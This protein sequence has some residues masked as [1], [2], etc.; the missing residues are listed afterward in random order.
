MSVDYGSIYEAILADNRQLRAQVAE[1]QAAKAG[2]WQ[3]APDGAYR[4]SPQTVIDVDD[5]DLDIWVDPDDR[6]R[7]G[8]PDGV[9]LCRWEPTVPE[10]GATVN[11]FGPGEDGEPE[12]IGVSVY[13]AASKSWQQTY[14]PD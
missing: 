10:D 2:T 1:L 3:P 14:F 8:L 5:A 9:R 4:I 11:I 6:V 12:H 13:D 7:I